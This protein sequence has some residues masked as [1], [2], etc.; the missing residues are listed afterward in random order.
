MKP[1][2]MERQLIVRKET[3]SNTGITKYDNKA[4][5][6]FFTLVIILS[7]AAEAYI[8]TDGPLWMYFVLMWIPAF[9]AIIASAIALKENN[10]KFS[11]K[12]FLSGLGI[13]RCRIR[14]I[15]L[16]VFIPLIYLLI[17]YMIYWK[18]HPDNFGYTGVALSLI[19]KDCLPTLIIGI[20]PGILSAM[21]E[22]I[23]WRGY[24]LPALTERSGLKKA[25]I[26]TSLFWCCWHL[27]L[28]AFGDY[29]AGA[30]VWY[31]LPAF[32]LCIFPVGIIIGGLT[33]LSKSVWP[34]AFLHAAHNNYDQAVFG[35][36]TRGDDMMYYVSETG[37]LTIICG[38]VIAII[39][40]VKVK[41]IAAKE[42]NRI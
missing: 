23:G 40:I 33:Y 15:L 26:I 18:T 13:R 7:L 19:L 30:P 4:L 16:A 3:M 11:L 31:K 21:G 28:L 32:V 6:S 8:I 37:F 39:M 41:D 1:E 36:I 20:F 27:P 34:A 25:L 10:E 14:Y 35:V 24:M 9:S 12:G 2:T 29:M 22:E 38:W 42:E 17:P 5:I